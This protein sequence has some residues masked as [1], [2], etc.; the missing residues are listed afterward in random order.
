MSLSRGMLTTVA[1]I[2]HWGPVEPTVKLARQLDGVSSVTDLV[3][4]AN[5]GSRRPADMPENADWLIPGANLGFGGGFRFGCEAR[6]EAD[7]YLLL[8]NDVSLPEWTVDACLDLICQDGVGVVGPTLLNAHGI[9]P[10]P[11]TL[12][13]LF[14]VR[15]RRRPVPRAME[16]A[17]IL[18]AVMFIRAECYRRVPMDTRYFLYYEETDFALRVRAAGWRIM[19]S[20]YQAWHRNGATVSHSACSYYSVRNRLWFARIHGRRWQPVVT[21][22]WVTFV[23]IPRAIMSNLRRGHGLSLVRFYWHGLLDGMGK[24]PEANTI[25]SD[26]PRPAR[27]QRPGDG[28]RPNRSLSES[29]RHRFSLPRPRPSAEGGIHADGSSVDPGLRMLDGTR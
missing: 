4:V 23:S 22:V 27:W 9:N 14:T 13:P 28:G 2:V 26:E 5:D 16:V 1:I 7:V 20:P 24:L 12:T 10:G 11:G 3:V 6:P 21:A 19:A 8:N 25:C 29:V 15:W 17:F 18:G